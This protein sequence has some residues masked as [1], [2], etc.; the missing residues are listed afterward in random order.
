MAIQYK[1]TKPKK[2]KPVKIKQEKAVKVK[3]EKPVKIKQEKPVKIKQEKP[4]KIKQE[5]PVK[6]KQAKPVKIRKDDTPSSTNNKLKIK[7]SFNAG[8]SS[9][10]GNKKSPLGFNSTEDKEKESKKI[11]IFIIVACAILVLA[12]AVV[13]II[14]FVKYSNNVA[15]DGKNIDSVYIS[16]YP[17]NTTYY[18]GDM[19]PDY[20]GLKIGITLK[21]GT[22]HYVE[23][24]HENASEFTFKGFDSSAYCEEQT[25]TVTYKGYDCEFI[26]SIKERPQATPILSNISLETL[27]KTEY[28]V[29]EWLS[30]TGGVILLEYK[31]HAPL[32]VNLMNKDVYGWEEAYQAGPGTYTL[33]VVYVDWDTGIEKETTYEITIEE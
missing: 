19:K 8:S 31:N 26:I 20:S 32:R 3:Q 6:V 10:L 12:L 15:A 24:S 22:N 14:L 13:G 1:N 5:K 9:K 25:I 30:T 18:I 29:G 16:A 27:P 33:T 11:R 21:N 28:K 17:K 2:E 23:Y 7:G 4:V